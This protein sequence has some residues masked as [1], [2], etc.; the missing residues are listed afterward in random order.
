M[1][2]M[3]GYLADGLHVEVVDERTD[4]VGLVEYQIKPVGCE[5]FAS[6]INPWIRRYMLFPT[7]PTKSSAKTGQ[8]E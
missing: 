2:R 4:V 1:D 6:G 5:T 3:S 8:P 7:N